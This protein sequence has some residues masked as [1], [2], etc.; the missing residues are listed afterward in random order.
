LYSSILFHGYGSFI[1]AWNC[2]HRIGNGAV[3]GCGFG[4]EG[5]QDSIFEPAILTMGLCCC[6]RHRNVSSG[7]Y[8]VGLDV[9]VTRAS[10][11]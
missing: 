8:A 2:A 6:G 3:D 10:L 9:L 7:K 1:N 4:L 5:D 11:P